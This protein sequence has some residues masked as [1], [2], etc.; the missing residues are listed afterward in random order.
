MDY[1]MISQLNIM[2]WS[3]WA[4]LWQCATYGSDE[5]TEMAEDDHRFTRI[6]PDHV[7]L[8]VPVGAG[9]WSAR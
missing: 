9:A 8:A 1:G 5:V 7:F 4:R 2:A 6:E 3:S